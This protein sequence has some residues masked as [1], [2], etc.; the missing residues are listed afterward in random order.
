MISAAQ[1]GA[2]NEAVESIRSQASSAAEAEVLAWYDAH[3]DADVAEAREAAREIL[4]GLVQT[5]D[6]AGAALAASWYDSRGKA[7]GAKLDRAVTSVTYTKGDVDKLVRYQ[8]DK[9]VSGDWDGFAAMCGE[10]AANDAMKSVNRTVLSNARRDSSKGVRFARVTSGLNTC[11]FC[12]MLAG[13][14]AVYNSRKSAGEFDHWHRHCT[15]KVVPSFTGN[16][17]EVLVEGHDPKKIEGRLKEVESLT[18]VKRGTKEFTREVSLRDPEW[19]LGGEAATDYAGNSVENYGEFVASGDYS[20]GGIVNRGNEWRDLWA[21]HALEQNGI[22]AV[23]H[24]ARDLDLTINGEWWEV[25]SPEAPAE[26]PK[27]G[28]ELAFVERELRKASRQFEKRGISPARVVFN[29][30]YRQVADDDA[31]TS[32]L[33]KRMPMHHI[34]EVLYVAGDGRVVRL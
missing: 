16:T 4:S 19:L 25:K 10:Y 5:Y 24:G 9:L 8:A 34:A 30:R 3:P 27:A 33:R 26:S 23:A 21:H 6:Q 29:A 22:K 31:I 2:Y 32:E 1:W 13:R 17:Y 7:A 15:C 28:R 11:A 14:G 18:G 20:A 12:L